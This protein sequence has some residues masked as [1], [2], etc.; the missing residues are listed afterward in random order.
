MVQEP[1]QFKFGN[2]QTGSRLTGLG[3]TRPT[4]WSRNRTVSRSSR[5]TPSEGHLVEIRKTYSKKT[6]K[7]RQRGAFCGNMENLWGPLLLSVCVFV[8][9][10]SLSLSLSV[11][12]VCVLR[13]PVEAMASELDTLPPPPLLLPT[14]D[15]SLCERATARRR[16]PQ[17]T[18]FD[19]S[20]DCSGR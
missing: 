2:S 20:S 4:Q 8:F 10:V 6:E 19:P 13:W 14:K 5:D 1:V 17:R 7:E 11:N 16:H 12:R 18:R 15:A 3:W 9:S